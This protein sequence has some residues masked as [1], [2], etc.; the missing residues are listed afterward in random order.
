MITQRPFP[1]F[2]ILLLLFSILSMGGCTSI[3]N[4]STDTPIVPDPSKRTFG[5]Y[6]DDQ[7]IE[8]IATVNLNKTS[9]ELDAANISVHAYNG[10]VLLCGQVQSERARNL[11]A[12]V[13]GDLPRVRQVHNE[14]HVQGNT[15]LIA[16]TNDA[17]L[18]TKLKTKLIANQDINSSR[19]K[20]VTENGTAYLMGMV[21]R[22]QAEKITNVASNT[23]G[24]QR[25][26]RV[27]EYID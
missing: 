4:A 21:T 15:S 24:I 5:T 20:V 12:K 18:A 14:L 17:W 10:V 9:P 11:A 1:T 22:I 3:L 13:V 16:S 23:Q 19:V 6:W 27:F 25:V 8:S 2:V 26:V 7:Q